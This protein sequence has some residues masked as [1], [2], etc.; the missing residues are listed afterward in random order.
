MNQT[1]IHQPGIPYHV[2]QNIGPRWKCI[3]GAEYLRDA[4]ILAMSRTYDTG[5]AHR[6]VDNDS[7]VLAEFAP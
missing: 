4:T 2:E 3:G 1:T 5:R 6:V 7:R